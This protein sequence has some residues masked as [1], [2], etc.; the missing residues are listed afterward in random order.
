MVNTRMPESA[1]DAPTDLSSAKNPLYT[2]T[3]AVEPKSAH[4]EQSIPYHGVLLDSSVENPRYMK[5]AV[6]D[7]QFWLSRGK[8]S[9]GQCSQIDE[10]F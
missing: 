6:L 5:T 1:Q 8:S 2:A 9:S 10:W 3:S 7:E 4:R